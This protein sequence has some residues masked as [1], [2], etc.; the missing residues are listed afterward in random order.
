MKV[1]FVVFTLFL[2]S[3]GCPRIISRSE[4][5]GQRSKCT[6]SLKPPMTYALIH[7]TEGKRC[8]STSSCSAQMRNVQSYHMNS[9]KWCDIGYS[10]L[11]GEDGN[12]YEGRGWKTLGA[13]TLNYNSVG[14]GICFLGNFM[15]VAPGAQALNAAQQLIKCAV[16]KGLL[17][18]S[19]IL[20]GH[21]QLGS[22]DCPG[23]TLYNI[24]KK[25]PHWQ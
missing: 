25:W 23:T 15:G 4:W 12:V 13:H 5:G 14:Y 2:C 7:H 8:F 6:S 19:Y 20:K 11:I 18:S 9:K 1:A 10:F 17:K 21:R 24:I 3:E 16:S 22:T